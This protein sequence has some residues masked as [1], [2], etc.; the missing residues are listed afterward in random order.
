MIMMNSIEEYQNL[1]ELLKKTLEFYADSRN[2][3]GPMGNIAPIDLDEHGFQARFALEKVKELEELNKK[4]MEDYDKI[5]GGYEQLQASQDI[6]DPEK[7]I[8]LYKLMNNDK[9]V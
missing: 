5:V 8:E 1:V 2:Y 9:N 4:I 6:V 7:L 3:D